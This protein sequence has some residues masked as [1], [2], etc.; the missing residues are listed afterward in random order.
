MRMGRR[1]SELAPMYPVQ[2]EKKARYA[3]NTP[4]RL[5]FRPKSV[6]P[7]RAVRS[8]RRSSRRATRSATQAPK[9]GLLASHSPRRT[10]K[11]LPQLSSRQR[12]MN[13]ILGTLLDGATDF[14]Q[15]GRLL[16]R[17][18]PVNVVG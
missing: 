2:C 13:S 5:K 10:K 11:P 9:A 6:L 4:A 15:I 1:P 18:D 8:G 7:G 14:L 16:G 17:E 3:L 12:L